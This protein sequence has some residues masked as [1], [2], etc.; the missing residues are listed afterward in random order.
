MIRK[1]MSRKLTC[2]ILISLAFMVGLL[3]CSDPEERTRVIESPPIAPNPEAGPR[4]PVAPPRRTGA[5]PGPNPPSGPVSPTRQP[6]PDSNLPPDVAGPG[7]GE[8]SIAPRWLNV[9]TLEVQ[10]YADKT[11]RIDVGVEGTKRGTEI[12]CSFITRH[13]RILTDKKWSPLPVVIFTQKDPEEKLSQLFEDT[14]DFPVKQRSVASDEITFLVE[15]TRKK[16]FRALWRVKT[17]LV[18]LDEAP[19]CD[20]H[21]EICLA[22]KAVGGG[23]YTCTEGW[24]Q[25]QRLITVID[26]RRH[27]LH[28]RSPEREK[29]DLVKLRLVLKKLDPTGR[30]TGEPFTEEFTD[31]TP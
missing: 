27:V 25:I 17:R 11:V 5:Y 10:D 30:P 12:S 28:F 13:P 26:P 19:A 6:T 18:R 8:P 16:V 7:D 9:A 22:P 14:L 31:F 3:G 15:F 24:R 1:L 23:K 29:D 4:D 2:N 21:V 20:A